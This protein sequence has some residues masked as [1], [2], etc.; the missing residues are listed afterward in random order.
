MLFPDLAATPP[1]NRNESRP[2]GGSDIFDLARPSGLAQMRPSGLQAGWVNYGR[3]PAHLQNPQNH[4]DGQILLDLKKI[5]ALV[6][7]PQDVQ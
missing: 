5:A 6:R 4:E 2:V 7:Q 3:G 1:A